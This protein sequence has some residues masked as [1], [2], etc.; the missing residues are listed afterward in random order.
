M[1]VTIASDS[2]KGSASSLQVAQAIERGIHRADPSVVCRRF[3]VADGGEGLLSALGR[4]GDEEVRIEVLGPLFERREAAYLRRGDL[5]IIEMA[6]ASGLPLVPED[7]RDPM[8]TTTYGTG[9]LIADA[10]ARGCRRLVVGIGGSATNDGGAGMA[11][12]LGA[13]LLDRDGKAVRPN[14]GGL[15]RIEAVDVSSMLPGLGETEI[16]VACDVDNPLCGPN[17]AS[18]VFGPQKGATPQM[19]ERLDRA[20]ARYARLLGRQDLAAVPG[21]GAAGGLGF[22]LMAFCGARLESGVELALS[23]TG[24]EEALEDSDLVITGEGRIDGQSARGKVPVGVARLAK[25]RGLPVLVLAGDIGPGT[26]ALYQ[27]GIDAIASTTPAAM[28]LQEAM[29]RSL[30]LTEDAAYRTWRLVMMALRMGKAGRG[31]RD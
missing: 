27:M 20:L 11:A 16:R 29:A 2:F 26:E 17:G 15:E 7:R 24:I 6:R 23:A 28:G 4:D 25:R 1:V 21:S 13:R 3:P 18:A 22:A 12:A 14:G 10:I 5:A 9:Q 8:R 31:A 19:V 30:E